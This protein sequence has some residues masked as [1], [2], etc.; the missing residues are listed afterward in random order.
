MQKN[1]SYNTRAERAFIELVCCGVSGNSL[2]EN[3]FRDLSREDWERIYAMA[4]RQTVCGICYKAYCK[5]PDSLLPDGHLLSRWVARVNAIETFNHSMSEAVTSLVSMLREHG[6]HP[7]VQ[8]GLSVARFYSNPEL[9]ECGDIDLW[10]PDPEARR[11]V[12]FLRG[13]APDL[14]SHPDGSKSFVY[15][16]F[17]VE[18]HPSLINISRPF[19]SYD[20]E[21]FAIKRC[22]K[23]VDN[24]API[25][26][27]PP[28]LELLLINVHIMK[29]AFGTGIGLRHICDYM[30]AS[31]ALKGKYKE[32]EFEEACSILGLSK[33]TALL[34]EF[35]VKILKASPDMLPPTSYQKKGDMPIGSLLR[36][37]IEGGN[38]GHHL[39]RNSS[40]ADTPARGKFHTISM[41]LKRSRFAASIAPGEAFWSF[42]R[43]MLGQIH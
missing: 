22:A 15:S 14:K 20:L 23:Y 27:P 12:E 11:A 34:N 9:R 17:V 16:G 38:F 1:Q 42:S 41:F 21:T 36:I 18:L 40:A 2:D 24:E 30:C 33:W 32:A 28:L 35:L 3:I 5:L 10:L 31:Y 26:S 19:L 25:P 4:K 37:I 39:R 6:F 29:H 43:L 13:I 7:V 8:K